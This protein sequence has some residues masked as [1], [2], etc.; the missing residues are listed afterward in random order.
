MSVKI[1][2]VMPVFNGERF[3]TKTLDSMLNQTF[4]DFE[5][6][7]INDASTDKSLSIL[8][9]Y[10]SRLNL[11]VIDLK[12]N[13]GRVP[14][15]I[16]TY[17]IPNVRGQYFTYLSQDD[18]LSNDCFEQMFNTA[19][20][21]NADAVIPDFVYYT[22]KDSDKKLVGVNGNRNIVL[23]GR[24]AFNLSLDWTIP[25]AALWNMEIVRGSGY[26][27][28]NMFADEYSIRKFFLQCKKV[29]FCNGIFFYSI[30]NPEAITK[31]MKPALFSKVFK[32]TRLLQLVYY[33]SDQKIFRERLVNLINMFYDYHQILFQQ[34]FSKTEH[35]IAR[36]ELMEAFGLFN[37]FVKEIK[38]VFKETGK[39]I[40]IKF[41]VLR[42]NYV[43]FYFFCR[44][45]Y[46][47]SR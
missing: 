24:D 4:K 15:I 39:N 27:D 37:D 2:A 13:L 5:I 28:F 41:F 10:S 1:S 25:G 22:G 43:V 26:E 11:N 34:K 44:V 38:L 20:Q 42:S 3:L 36:N 35:T 18:F 31:K 33:N 30:N 21:L 40:R 14:Y 47:L 45:K 23:T 17:G 16:K 32:E 19:R 8:N 46:L 9:Q 6:I 7:C 29:T 12:S